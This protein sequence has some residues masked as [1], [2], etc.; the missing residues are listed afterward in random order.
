MKQ[1][2]GHHS[3]RAY[4]AYSQYFYTLI[5]RGTDKLRVFLEQNKDVG[6]KYATVVHCDTPSGVLN[7]VKDICKTLKSMGAMED[8]DNGEYI[9]WPKL[10]SSTKL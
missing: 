9:Q 8:K 5:T 2:V 10:K 7:N 4:K 3:F 6:Y 1:N